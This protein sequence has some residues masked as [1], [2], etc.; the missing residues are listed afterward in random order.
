[1]EELGS[2]VLNVNKYI[3]EYAGKSAPVFLEGIV[4]KMTIPL[5][6]AK[7]GGVNEGAVEGATKVNDAVSDIV[8]ERLIKILWTIHSNTGV[9]VS[10]VTGNLSVSERTI[11]EYLCILSKAGLIEYIGS[12]KTGHYQISD[13]LHD[14]LHDKKGKNDSADTGSRAIKSTKKT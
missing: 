5:P 6:L 7:D 10:D 8:R 3:K 1:M 9:K 2:G 12:K 13:K 4:F 11:K 14:K